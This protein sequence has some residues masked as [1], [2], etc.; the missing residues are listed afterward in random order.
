MKEFDNIKITELTE[1]LNENTTLKRFYPLIPVRG[2]LMQKLL[3]EGMEDKYIFLD[4]VNASVP[5]SAVFLQGL[6][7][8]FSMDERILGLFECFMH[9]HDFTNRKLSEIQSVDAGFIEK[10]SLNHIKMSKDYLLLC[11]G[12]SAEAISEKYGAEKND[13]LWLFGICDLM[14][15]PGVK[16]LRA[17]LYYDCGYRNLQ[18]F[19]VQN[20]PEMRKKLAAYIAENKIQKSVPFA[21]ELETQIAVAKVLPHLSFGA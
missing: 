2:E 8:K 19:S 5:D 3:P 21:K 16:E 13:V 14:R 20:Q 6:A 17:S 1:L 11:M 10:L 7:E 9:L 4:A 15:L 12:N 18:I